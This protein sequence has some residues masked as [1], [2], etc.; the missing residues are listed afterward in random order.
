ME[1]MF[2]VPSQQSGIRPVRSTMQDLAKNGTNLLCKH[3]VS[4]CRDDIMLTLRIVQGE[5]VL[6]KKILM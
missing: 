6:G 4:L 1:K 5:I 3:F 2:F